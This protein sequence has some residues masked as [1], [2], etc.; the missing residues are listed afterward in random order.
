MFKIERSNIP[1]FRGEAKNEIKL[2]KLE[3]RNLTKNSFFIQKADIYIRSDENDQKLLGSIKFEIP[4]KFL[5]SL[6]S[7]TGIEVARIFIT[8]DTLLINDR[9]NRVLYYGKPDF[10]GR[11]YGMNFSVLPLIFGDFVSDDIIEG[12]GKCVDGYLNMNSFKA[13]IRIIYTI[14][15]QNG[16]PVSAKE[17]GSLSDAALEFRYENF[18][19][20]DSLIIPGKIYMKSL[21]MKTEVDMK[22][23]KLEYPWNG[24]VEFIP[25]KNYEII[26]LL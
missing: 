8:A 23:D 10:I 16:K 17:E 25:G 20:R 19:N 12:I 1:G 15:C 21:R 4:D 22:I 24:N 2:N 14:N 26:P 18:I 5:I 13:G 3:E 6:R 11:K 9:I 7:K